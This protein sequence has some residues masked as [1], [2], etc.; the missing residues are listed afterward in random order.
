[1]TIDWPRRFCLYAFPG[2][3]SGQAEHT[4]GLSANK[5]RFARANRTFDDPLI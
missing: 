5:K 3:P 4:S 2:R 1:M